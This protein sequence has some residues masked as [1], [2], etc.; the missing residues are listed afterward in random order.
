MAVACAIVSTAASCGGGEAR[1]ADSQAGRA[2]AMMATPPA[3]LGLCRRFALIR[4]SCPRRV[5]SAPYARTPRPPG[6]TGPSAGGAFAHCGGRSG[7]AAIVMPGCDR[8][9]W[10]IEAGAPAGL[11]PD[12]PPGL[13]GERLAPGART[14]PPQYVH[15][16]VYAARGSL[17]R[18]FPFAWPRGAAR[19]V[20]DSLLGPKR[21]ES[22]LLGSR[23]WAG[24]DGTLVLAPPLVFGG[25]D[26][27]HLMFRWR[28]GGVDRV[29]SVHAWTP[30][31][32]AV[33]TLEAV[34]TSAR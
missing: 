26:G 15:I 16:G 1:D 5:P 8:P 27:D 7:G 14:R 30:L 21:T 19:S 32:D 4:P 13:P 11:P 18:T 6:F 25:E 33:A 34:V 28:K 17:A 3:A 2:V 20:E 9:R 31:R 24:V 23:R 12:A 29:V 10:V 22:I